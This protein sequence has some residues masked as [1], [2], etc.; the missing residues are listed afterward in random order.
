MLLFSNR[1]IGVVLSLEKITISAI[2]LGSDTRIFPGDFVFRTTK[3]MGVYV[4]RAL[5]GTIINPLG[6]SLSNKKESNISFLST[7]YYAKGKYVNF[8][9]AFSIFYLDFSKFAK[10]TFQGNFTKVIPSV[11][12]KY[13]R[14][15][16]TDF[17]TVLKVRKT[18]SNFKNIKDFFK[19]DDVV[20]TKNAFRS[21][22]V[23][24]QY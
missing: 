15:F 23:L 24:I 17:S 8:K 9:D 14:G 4:S 22:K 1:G 10:L 7:T 6:R 19:S 2:V 3:L 18:F 21:Y 12:Y 13:M 5:L 11:K 20:F 16:V